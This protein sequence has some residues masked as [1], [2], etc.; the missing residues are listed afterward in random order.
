MTIERYDVNFR[1]MSEDELAEWKKHPTAIISDAQNRAQTMSA[2]IRPL[3]PDMRLVGQAR[4]I[5]VPAADNAATHVMLALVR[6][7]EVIVI[8]GAGYTD[9]AVWGGVV[10][11]AAIRAKAAGVVTDGATRDS[12]EIAE[13]GFPLFCSGVTP[14]GPQKGNYGMIDGPIAL[15]RV[16]VQS[17]DLI[18]GDSDGVV[19][20]PLNRLKETLA[21]VKKIEE[22]EAAMIAKLEAGQTTA[23]IVGVKIPEVIR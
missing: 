17:G 5:R 11:L 15:G 2:S 23:E 4:T 8:D 6:P 14:R 20:V 9:T 16:P 18:V 3:H 10:T 1:R 21:E 19:V 22:R 12:Q 7:G 13:K